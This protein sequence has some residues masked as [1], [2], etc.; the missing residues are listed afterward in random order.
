VLQRLDHSAIFLMIADTYTP[1]ATLYLHGASAFGLT[2]SIWNAALLGIGA[3][4]F[5]KRALEGLSARAYLALGW[6]GV[7]ATGPFLASLRALTL[8]LL[9]AGGLLY[10]IG[11]ICQGKACRF[12]KRYGMPS[13]SPARDCTTRPCSRALASCKERDGNGV[14]FIRTS[15]SVEQFDT[16]ETVQAYKALP[17]QIFWQCGIGNVAK[18]NAKRSQRAWK[19]AVIFIRV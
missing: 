6:V 1:F 4:L 17:W 12:R 3:K 2:A 8:L 19:T 14:D 7:V 13:F 5:I 18:C 9:A 11:V 16:A 10:S 15:V